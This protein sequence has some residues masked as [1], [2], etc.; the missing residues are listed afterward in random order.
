M[1]LLSV[2]QYKTSLKRLLQVDEGIFFRDAIFIA[3][4]GA[5]WAHTLQLSIC[6]NA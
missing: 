4:L 2:K 3:E 1:G 6:E 5:K